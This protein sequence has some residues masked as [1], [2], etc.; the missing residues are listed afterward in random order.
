[1]AAR[2]DAGAVSFSDARTRP[3][4]DAATPNETIFLD[5]EIILKQSGALIRP[6]GRGA[7]MLPVIPNTIYRQFFHA[8][9]PGISNQGAKV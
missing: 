2:G 3:K 6:V 7:F 9:L 4:S 5:L 1:L 8:A